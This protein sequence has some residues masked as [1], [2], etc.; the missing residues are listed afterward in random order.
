MEAPASKRTPEVLRMVPPDSAIVH[1]RSRSPI[2]AKP[3][4]EDAHER[5][6]AP[7][8]AHERSRSPIGGNL[9][10]DVHSGELLTADELYDIY[11]KA[12]RITKHNKAK[13]ITKQERAQG[14]PT[15][16]M[17]QSRPASHQPRPMTNPPRTNQSRLNRKRNTARRSS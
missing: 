14:K 12:K 7:I 11:F 10:M 3:P 1:E 8:V 4:P 17:A 15:T 13:R 16:L 9:F 2:V 5:S 6:L